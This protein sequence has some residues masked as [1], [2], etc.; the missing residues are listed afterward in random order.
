MH[1]IHGIKIITCFSL[2][3]RTVTH[4]LDDVAAKMFS[5][6]LWVWRKSVRY[7]QY[8]VSVLLLMRLKVIRAEGLYVVLPP[9]EGKN[10]YVV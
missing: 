7:I 4:Q 10:P 9:N 2:L 8:K 1:G 6:K 5:K 3:I